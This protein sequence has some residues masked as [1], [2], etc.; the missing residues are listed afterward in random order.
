M[1]STMRPKTRPQN[2][3]PTPIGV[4]SDDAQILE[5]IA[6]RLDKGRQLCA[7]VSNEDGDQFGPVGAARVGGYSMYRAQRFEERL[8]DIEY[9]HRAVVQLRPDLA[10]GDIGRDDAAMTVRR[11]EAARP[12][13]HPDNRHSL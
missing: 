8:T 4:T 5:G 9:L 13:G 7:F 10:L 12:V 11:R 3:E 2:A 6:S 1:S